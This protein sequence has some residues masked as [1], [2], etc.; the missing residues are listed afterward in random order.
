MSDQ[1]T[2]RGKTEA[3]GELESVLLFVLSQHGD[4]TISIYKSMM[5]W[6]ESSRYAMTGDEAQDRTAWNRHPCLQRS[7][8]CQNG[9][10]PSD[11]R[12]HNW[13]KEMWTLW[14]LLGGGLISAPDHVLTFGRPGNVA[15]CRM[16]SAGEAGGLA[17]TAPGLAVSVSAESQGHIILSRSPPGLVVLTR[18]NPVYI[19]MRGLVFTRHK[20][21]APCVRFRSLA[22]KSDCVL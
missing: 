22:W 6:V 5:K 16:E 13:L 10:T 21:W 8:P 19:L 1:W 3:T 11:P 15:D 2:A 7:P 4:G 17:R 18:R 9:R 20:S 14:W 12:T